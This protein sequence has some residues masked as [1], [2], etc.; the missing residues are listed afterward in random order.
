MRLRWR[1]WPSWRD[2][3]GRAWREYG[4]DAV[5]DRA[6]AL[7]FYFVFSLFPFLFFLTTL[8][9]YIPQAQGSLDTLMDRARVFLP[10]EAMTLIETHLR[11]L[12][13]DS[14]PQLLTLSLAVALYSASRGVD[15]VRNAMNL[16]Y[17]VRESRPLWK[18]ELLAF[19]VTV[20]GGLLILVGIS[21][22][23]AGSNA[24]LWAA[25]KLGIADGYVLVFRWIRWPI[26]AALIMLGAALCY[27]VLP[28]TRRRFRFV[29][30][31]SVSGTLVWF[32]ATLGF[33]MYVSHFGSYNVTYGAIGGV[34]VLMTWFYIT[35]FIL[36]MGGE[37]NA[38]LEEA[39]PAGTD[40]P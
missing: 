28:D 40:P 17:D 37:I 33:G 9:A 1:S 24:G 15:A 31:G 21:A 18:T 16:A 7:S 39:A 3:L 29:T 14:R 38:I 20:G 8:A 27:H 32:L 19:G 35:G 11:G 22:V 34:I 6:A 36:L 13:N 10:P 25:D 26:T 2:F 30:P 5:A 23:M 4:N 12:V